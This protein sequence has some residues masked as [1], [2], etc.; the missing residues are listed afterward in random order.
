MVTEL[1][2]GIECDGQPGR[3]ASRC[4][5][6]VTGGAGFIGANL[7]RRLLADRRLDVVA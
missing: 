1:T 7:C 3:L 4:K 5:M 6:V 2:P